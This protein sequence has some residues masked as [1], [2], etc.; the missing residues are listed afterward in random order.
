MP[1]RASKTIARL[2]VVPWSMARMWLIASLPVPHVLAGFAPKGAAAARPCQARRAL[3]KERSA[4]RRGAA[5]LA[6]AQRLEPA[7]PAAA[8]Q[9]MTAAEWGL[10]VALSILWGGSFF[11]ASVALRELPP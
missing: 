10:L 11:F 8:R 2:E 7:M 9:P 4:C 5:T 6:G 1:M 3:R